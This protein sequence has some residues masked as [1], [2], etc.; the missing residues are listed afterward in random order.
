METINE[1]NQALVDILQSTIIITEVITQNNPGELDK[2]DEDV[3]NT[4]D[5]VFDDEEFRDEILSS[6]CH[7]AEDYFGFQGY[8]IHV[9]VA[10]K[11]LELKEQAKAI[12]RSEIETPNRGDWRQRGVFYSKDI[13][14]LKEEVKWIAKIYN[15]LQ[16]WEKYFNIEFNLYEFDCAVADYFY[17]NPI[18]DFDLP[19]DEDI[20]R[21]LPKDVFSIICDNFVDDL[22]HGYTPKQ[23]D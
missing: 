16:E 19:R 2:F 7:I 20:L 15:Q 21:L 18:F 1:Y 11:Y 4:M 10:K 12:I 3:K 23:E 8:G 17:N 6:W 22:G 5:F 9:K 14:D 13:C